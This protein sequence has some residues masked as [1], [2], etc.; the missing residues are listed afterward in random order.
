MMVK[1]TF[2]SFKARQDLEHFIE[3][4]SSHADNELYLN[5]NSN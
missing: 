3:C 4:K 1:T 5:L 2:K